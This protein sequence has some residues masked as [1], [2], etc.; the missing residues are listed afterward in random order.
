MALTYVGSL[1]ISLVNVG[2]AATPPG[3]TQGTLKLA[4]DIAKLD[5]AVIAQAAISATFP[6]NVVANA[7]AI[8][9]ALDPTKLAAVFALWLTLNADA[10]TDL[11][12]E[13]VGIEAQLAI[14][15]GI[16]GPL[17]LG[18]DAGSLSGWTYAGTARGFGTTLEAATVNGFGGVD[19]AANVNAI[20]IGAPD[21]S[22]W[23]TFGDAF[24]VGTS[25]DADLGAAT[26]QTDLRALG[27]LNGGQWNT[28]V[29][30][31]LRA[32]LTFQAALEGRKTVLEAQIQLTLGIGLPDPGDIIDFGLTIDITAALENLV[33]IQTDLDL[34]IANINI[35]IDALNLL[36]GEIN[37]QLGVAGISVWSYSGP[38]GQLG[39][40]FAPE[41]EGGMPG[42][43]KASAPAY[44][45]V[46]ASG[47]PSAWADF[48]SICV[49]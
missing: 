41:V 42:I 34:A 36:I 31:T 26:T 39:S 30:D 12:A 14:V 6:P 25:D 20:I 32:L 24:N 3:F 47:S 46:I 16:T 45:V 28:G 37:A 10:N 17:Q 4:A 15:A 2:L 23:G 19:R 9:N 38:A 35:Q 22:A 43:D 13:L 8:V 21:F 33:N 1:P 48:G 44:G 18:V 49:T 11:A 29:D 5:D 7:A 40:S 27:V